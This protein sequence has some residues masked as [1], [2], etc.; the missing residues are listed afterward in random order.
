MLAHCPGLG[1]F[2]LH[3]LVEVREAG[4]GTGRLKE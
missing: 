1:T 2:I 4:T 3:G